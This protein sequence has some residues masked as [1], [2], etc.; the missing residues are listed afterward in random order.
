M[1]ISGIKEFAEKLKERGYTLN[2]YIDGE[3]VLVIGKNA[4]PGLLGMFAPVEIKNLKKVLE[5]Y[6]GSKSS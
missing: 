5:I 6:A 1:D 3:L 4:K 2:V